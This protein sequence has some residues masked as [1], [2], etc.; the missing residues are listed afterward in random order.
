MHISLVIYIKAERFI[1]YEITGDK[2]EENV[3]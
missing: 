1:T 3:T 2:T